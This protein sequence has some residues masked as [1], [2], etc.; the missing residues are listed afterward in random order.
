[1]GSER[2]RARDLFQQSL[3]LC[4]EINHVSLL[5]RCLAG[6]AWLA[7]QRGAYAELHRLLEE[8]LALCQIHGD[9]MRRASVLE[10]LGFSALEQGEMAAAEQWF[11]EGLAL[12]RQQGA[13]GDLARGLRNLGVALTL[14]GR[15]REGYVRLAEA[16]SLYTEANHRLGLLFVT[17]WLGFA[18]LHLGEYGR[19]QGYG[20]EARQLAQEGEHQGVLANALWVL[21]SLALARGGYEESRLAFD[22]SIR[23]YAKLDQRNEQGTALATAAYGERASGNHQRAVHLLVQALLVPVPEAYYPRITALPVLALLLADRGDVQRAVEI[24]SLAIRS[25]Y[26]ANSQWFHHVAGRELEALMASLPP[27]IVAT[28]QERGKARDL[29]ATADELLAD[30]QSGFADKPNLPST[31]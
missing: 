31:K 30:L 15:F 24:Y 7:R 5:M 3:S 16:G 29:K 18:Q 6:L 13:A 26:L 8:C 12:R 4:R 1:M 22:E 23:L 21:G 20:Q 28:A 14:C 10:L 17:G 2:M 27:Q 11:D 9:P 19:A 25:P